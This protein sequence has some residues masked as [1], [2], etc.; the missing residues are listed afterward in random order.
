MNI[1]IIKIDKKKL[2]DWPFKLQYLFIYTTKVLNF[3]NMK[4]WEYNMRDKKRFLIFF[5]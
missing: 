3:M 5:S 1:Y 4:K 2:N